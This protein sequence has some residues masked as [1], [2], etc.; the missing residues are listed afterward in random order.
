[1][2]TITWCSNV[3]LHV[4]YYNNGI[5][6]DL[7]SCNY[8]SLDR[9]ITLLKHF[10]PGALM[11]KLDPSE[12]F[13]HVLVHDGDWELLWCT[14]P[15][16]IDSTVVTGYFF[17]T[18]L[19]F[20]LR[21]LPALFLNVH[22]GVPFTYFSERVISLWQ[23][24]GCPHPPLWYQ[25]LQADHVYVALFV[26]CLRFTQ[27]H[28]TRCT[29]PWCDQLLCWLPLRS[30]GNQV[31]PPLSDGQQASDEVVRAACSLDQLYVNAKE[32]FRSGLADSTQ[33]T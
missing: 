6:K 10:G 4:N 26:L 32:Y 19:L 3:V 7:F 31:P 5:P 11:S 8:D 17:D 29:H 12:A 24:V 30:A 14:W 1:M 28:V 15:V 25:S 23:S 9:A 13:R 18:F 16:K 21:S 20:G 22:G 33:R 2:L 27:H